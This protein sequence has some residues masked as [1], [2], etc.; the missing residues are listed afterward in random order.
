MPQKFNAAEAMLNKIS[1]FKIS[2][3]LYRKLALPKKCN[4]FHIDYVPFIEFSYFSMFFVIE[5]FFQFCCLQAILF[6]DIFVL[7]RFCFR[8][9]DVIPKLY[10]HCTYYIY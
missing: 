2:H 3:F 1:G 9:F 4:Y 7:R 5:M 6:C 8:H 10:V